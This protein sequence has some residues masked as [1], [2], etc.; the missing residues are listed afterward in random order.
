MPLSFLPLL[1]YFF[2]LLAENT[3]IVNRHS[4]EL[5]RIYS[6]LKFHFKLSFAPAGKEN[7]Q[8]QVLTE[9]Y[10]LLTTVE[11]DIQDSAGDQEL[12]TNRSEITSE[13]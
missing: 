2:Q 10:N 9:M 11:S 4:R 1:L 6:T 3:A 12:Y 7:F 8:H 13:V 5:V